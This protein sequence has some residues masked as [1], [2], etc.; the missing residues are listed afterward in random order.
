MGV[1]CVLGGMPQPV[2]LSPIRLTPKSDIHSQTALIP[3]SPFLL[4]VPCLLGLRAP[5]SLMRYTVLGPGGTDNQPKA[6]P[7]G[8]LEPPG[9]LWSRSSERFGVMG[10]NCALVVWG[11]KAGM[12][13]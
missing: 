6:M 9:I 1:G 5:F 4:T 2:I 10:M 8:N 3:A 12:L 7:S 11:S 13:M